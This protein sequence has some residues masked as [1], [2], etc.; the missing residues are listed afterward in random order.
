MTTTVRFRFSHLLLLIAFFAHLLVG[1]GPAQGFAWCL[2]TG[3][4]LRLE[5]NPQGSC[6]IID[7]CAETSGEESHIDYG[8]GALDAD[9]CGDCLDFPAVSQDS[10]TACRFSPDA[11]L[12]SFAPAALSAT[13]VS[14]FFP[15]FE[16]L[17]GFRPQPP[18][19]LQPTLALLRTVILRN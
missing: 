17:P 16:D 4:E 9:H 7:P 18:P 1:A 13:H 14:S 19:P 15:L 10:H 6:D 8:S 5:H 3:G 2:G 12:A 11:D